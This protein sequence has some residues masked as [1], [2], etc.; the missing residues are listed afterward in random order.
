MVRALSCGT[1]R[2]LLVV[3]FSSSNGKE[4]PL[5]FAPYPQAGKAGNCGNTCGSFISIYGLPTMC[6]AL[7]LYFTQWRVGGNGA[8]VGRCFLI[9]LCDKPNSGV[10]WPW[11]WG[12]I[13]S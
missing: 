2:T 10:P 1:A 7:T 11:D 12:V 8:Q 6:Q 9:L 5:L 13:L 4:G 3:S